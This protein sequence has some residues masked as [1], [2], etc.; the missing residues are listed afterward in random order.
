MK[1]EVRDD[2]CD[3]PLEF[4]K[5]YPSVCEDN[6]YENAFT[7][8]EPQQEPLPQANT[9][10]ECDPFEGQIFNN[11]DEAYEFYSVFTRKNGFSIRRDQGWF[12][13]ERLS[14]N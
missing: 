9:V 12:K 14:S 11:D 1:S 4:F 7:F 6:E 2:V 13:N 8:Q 3:W 5:D 10:D